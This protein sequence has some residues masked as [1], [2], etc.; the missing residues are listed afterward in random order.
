MNRNDAIKEK[1]VIK[2]EITAVT[3]EGSGVSRYKGAVVFTPFT[4]PGDSAEVKIEKVGK[5]CVYGKLER[6]L[7]PS[8]DRVNP[9]CPVFGECGGCALRHI[10]YAAET[11]IKTDWVAEHI[12][13]IGGFDLEPLPAIPSPK[14]DRYRNKAIYQA[15][16][17]ENG[18]IIFGFYRRKSHEIINCENCLLQPEEFEKILK[19]IKFFGE[20]TKISVYDESRHK[21]LLRAV[22]IRKGEVSGEI[23]VCLVI[24]GSRLPRAELLVSAL[25][26]Q[27]PQIVSIMLGINEERTNVVLGKRF[28]TLFGKEGISDTLCGVTVDI[29]PAAFYQVNHGAAELLYRKAGELAGLTGEE[30]LLDLYCGAG[31]IGLSMAAGA[32]RLI[33]VEIVPQA[34]ENAR[35]NAERMGVSNA[36]FIC[37]DAAQAAQTLQ[38]RGLLPDVVVLDPP[39]KG[40]DSATLSAV[41]AMNPKRIV[42]VSCDTATMA[43]D[44]KA[45]AELGYTPKIAQ[46][47]DMFPRTANVECAA[48]LVRENAGR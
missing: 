31:T 13:R 43:R 11:R 7:E 36:E 30:T 35:K 18:K 10:D 14:S 47:V 46:P 25:K 5:S 16:R 48:L 33:G 19:V 27:L 24:N 38:K 3:N 6:V 28:V 45:L 4:A 40:C 32:K 17:D 34:V 12:R 39:R 1:S 21:G 2:T 9:V 8:A 29:S 41:A 22:Y 23:G 20:Q 15:G 26:A 42:M 44:F 37:G